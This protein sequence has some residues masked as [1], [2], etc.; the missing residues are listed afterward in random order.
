M[1]ARIILDKKLTR[2][3]SFILLTGQTHEKLNELKAYWD[4]ITSRFTFLIEG[5]DTPLKKNPRR[6]S[7]E[8][9]FSS[10]FCSSQL[11]TVCLIF[12]LLPKEE[13]PTIPEFVM[14][15]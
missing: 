11:L 15:A 5:P 13:K 7:K 14:D 6:F 12:P 9:K 2:G 10:L 1:E 4:K 3:F 8:T